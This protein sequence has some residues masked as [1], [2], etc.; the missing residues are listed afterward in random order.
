M[1]E[2]EL[3]AFSELGFAD[4]HAVDLLLFWAVEF[5]DVDEA[6]RAVRAAS[7]LKLTPDQF[8][9]LTIAIIAASADARRKL[10]ASMCAELTWRFLTALPSSDAPAVGALPSAA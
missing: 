4:K 10:G 1:T 2:R 9:G 6:R 7:P 3:A 5:A 8:N